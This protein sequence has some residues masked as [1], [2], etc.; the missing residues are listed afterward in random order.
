MHFI[1]IAV[2]PGFALTY[3]LPGI[4]LWQTLLLTIASGNL[5]WLA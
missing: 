2:L 1:I 5:Y 4:Y 3:I